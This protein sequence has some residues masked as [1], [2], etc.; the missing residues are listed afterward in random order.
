MFGQFPPR[1]HLSGRLQAVGVAQAFD[2]Y[3][4]FVGI[5]LSLLCSI[6]TVYIVNLFCEQIWLY[7]GFQGV[8][9]L[10]FLLI[11]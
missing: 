5:F 1:I 8:L 7:Y 2:N 11:C 4:N 3:D 9:H 6:F 10:F